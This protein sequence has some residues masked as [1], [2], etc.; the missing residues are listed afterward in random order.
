M[1]PQGARNEGAIPSALYIS[2]TREGGPLDPRTC[3]DKTS[4]EQIIKESSYADNCFLRENDAQIM[5][6]QFYRVYAML[7]YY[8][9][10]IHEIFSNNSDVL[11]QIVTECG[12]INLHIKLHPSL[13]LNPK[14]LTPSSEVHPRE[15]H[16]SEVLPTEMEWQ[17]TSLQ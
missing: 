10:D 15:V 3:K 11:N 2:L 4:M 5:K 9:M 7:Q 14:T 6:E 1:S 17:S 13:I 16:P 12:E 8:G